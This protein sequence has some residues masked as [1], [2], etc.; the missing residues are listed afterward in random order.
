MLDSWVIP[1]LATPLTQLAKRLEKRGIRP[2]QVSL[3]GFALGM[4]AVPALALEGYWVALM[5]VVVN[6][7]CDG[8]DGALARIVG[9]TDRG[10]YLDITLDFIFYASVVFGFALADPAANALAAAALI[11]SFMGTGASFLA[12]A[13]MAQKREI[14]NIRLPNKGL[15]YIN[16]LAEGTETIAFLVAFCLFPTYFP[17]LA[18]V[19]CAICITT[20]VTRVYGGY[21]TLKD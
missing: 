20:T 5:L 4:L 10:G 6:R 12:F 15:Y 16:G 21:T 17:S 11:T 2:D 9:P 19:F 1:K 8:L 14:K 7:L 3:A 18:Y 13:I